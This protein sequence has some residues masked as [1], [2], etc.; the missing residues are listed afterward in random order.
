[1][2]SCEDFVFLVYVIGPRVAK[3]PIAM[4]SRSY[5]D[6]SH[7]SLSYSSTSMF[8][9]SYSDVPCSISALLPALPLQAYLQPR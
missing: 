8:T 4:F 1:M 3:A 6:D 2:P 7:T 5:S 9:R